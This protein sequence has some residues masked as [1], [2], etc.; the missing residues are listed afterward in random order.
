MASLVIFLIHSIQSCEAQITHSASKEETSYLT[1]MK[2]K[3]WYKVFDADPLVLHQCRN[4]DRSFVSVIMS[5][6]SQSVTVLC[7]ILHSLY[8]NISLWLHV[9]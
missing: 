5:I 3:T 2:E 6:R 8:L 7:P 1:S 9:V 4:L